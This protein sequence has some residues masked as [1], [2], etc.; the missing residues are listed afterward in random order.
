LP[1]IPSVSDQ[2]AFM[3]AAPIPFF[4]ALVA[5]A[6]LIWR[7]WRYRGIIDLLKTMVE[8]VKGESAIVGR[9]LG[10][11]EQKMSGMN[12][13]INTLKAELLK[14]QPQTQESLSSVVFR[15]T[16]QSRGASEEITRA[17]TANTAIT[18]VLSGPIFYP[19]HVQA[20]PPLPLRTSVVEPSAKDRAED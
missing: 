1:T 15:L 18:N 12:A 14:L 17:T 11:A 5:V 8:Q 19:P 2:F 7:E 13:E 4:L 9:S 20:S 3:L 10:Y 16:D 6:V